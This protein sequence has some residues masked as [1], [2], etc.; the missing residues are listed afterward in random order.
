LSEAIPAVS[1][2]TRIGGY[3]F[4]QPALRNYATRLAGSSLNHPVIDRLTP[5][6]NDETCVTVCKYLMSKIVSTLKRG[7]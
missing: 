5:P 1:P 6:A 2:A 7:R 4:A 3:R